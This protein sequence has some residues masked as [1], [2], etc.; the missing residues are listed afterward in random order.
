VLCNTKMYV[1]FGYGS[2]MSPEGMASKGLTPLNN[3][4]AILKG[5]RLAFNLAVPS[6]LVDPSYANIVPSEGDEVHGIAIVFDE[7][8]II[9]L[10]KAEM[11]YDRVKVQLTA[12]QED[13]GGSFVGYA[14]VFTP[15]NARNPAYSSFVAY[16][17]VP[18][19]QRYLN[20]LT[21]GGKKI[22]LDAKYV[23]DLEAHAVSPL[24][25]LADVLDDEAKALITARQFT[26]VEIEASKGQDPS[27]SVLKG[28]VIMK[29]GAMAKMAGGTDRT[30]KECL[31]VRVIES[32]AELGDDHKAWLNANV[33]AEII[34]TKQLKEGELG[35]IV[36]MTNYNEYDF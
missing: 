10:D 28:V 18:P 19:S 5:Y 21:S 32:L 35:G 8:D 6:S 2:N 11:C 9:A 13:S 33:A 1:Y 12:Y 25:V 17:E 3:F 23:A 7:K 36:G 14:Y 29:T 24:P 31:R 34:K 27:Y 20:M 22:N 16:N 30:F 4:R 15:E 26:D